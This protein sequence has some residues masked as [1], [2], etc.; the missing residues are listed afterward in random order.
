MIAFGGSAYEDDHIDTLYYAASLAV[1]KPQRIVRVDVRPGAGTDVVR[2][3]THA[4]VQVGVLS[5]PTFDARQIDV[6][7]IR[8]AG[9]PVRRD[10]G[11]RPIY[12]VR[13]VDGDGLGDI[14]IHID[15][16]DLPLTEANTAVKLWGQTFDDVRIEGTAS[17]VVGTP[18]RQGGASPHAAAPGAPTFAIALAADGAGFECRLAWLPNARV[19]LFDVT[20]RRIA[21]AVA[22]G[23]A[24][25][26]LTLTPASRPAPGLY[27]A[28]LTGPATL[29]RKV[30]VLR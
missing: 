19:E 4:T 8:V 28:R 2:P 30:L 9:V 5:E 15:A 18:G 21:S 23:G 12:S 3:G 22:A 27:F 24:A 6:G 13:D 25:Q 17:V 11:G 14:V 1:Q 26:T 29:T 20:G 16:H 10:G 7:S